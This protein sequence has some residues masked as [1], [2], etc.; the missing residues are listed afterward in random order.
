MTKLNNLNYSYPRS[1]IT[2]KIETIKKN[3]FTPKKSIYWDAKI[4]KNRDKNFSMKLPFTSNRC[5]KIGFQYK[6]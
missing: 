4:K 2:E 5:Q 1:L 6:L 3:K